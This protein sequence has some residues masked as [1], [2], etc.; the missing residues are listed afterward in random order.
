MSDKIDKRPGMNERKTVEGWLIGGTLMQ[1]SGIKIGLDGDMWHAMV[2]ENIQEGLSGFGK[3]PAEAI[4]EL[5]Y[6]IE[7]HGWNF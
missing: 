4:R 3:T 6:E 2:G 5:T 1:E 7:L